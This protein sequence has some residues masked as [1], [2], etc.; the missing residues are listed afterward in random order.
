MASTSRQKS[1][2]GSALRQWLHHPFIYVVYPSRWQSVVVRGK[3]P[4][5]EPS[6]LTWKWGLPQ[7]KSLRKELNWRKEELPEPSL[8][9]GQTRPQRKPRLPRRKINSLELGPD[10]PLWFLRLLLLS[11]EPVAQMSH[12]RERAG[13]ACGSGSVTLAWVGLQVCDNAHWPMIRTH[14]H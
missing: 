5:H 9:A 1:R 14:T 10:G 3:P 11:S 4:T 6:R 2:T 8:E 12:E 7:G 13:S